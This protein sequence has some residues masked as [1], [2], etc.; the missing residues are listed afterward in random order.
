MI[1]KLL[2]IGIIERGYPLFA[3]PTHFIP[4]T[5]PEL[6]VQEFVAQGNNIGDYVAGL[7][8]K[9]LR[10]TVRMVHD[11]FEANNVVF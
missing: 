1:E 5:R 4:K 2:S 3:A 11:F 6:S 8:N 7:E 10:L 9:Q